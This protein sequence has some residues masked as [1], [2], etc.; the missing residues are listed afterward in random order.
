MS[1]STEILRAYYCPLFLADTVSDHE[2]VQL[3]AF[4]FNRHFRSLSFMFV[5]LTARLKII[6]IMHDRIFFRFFLEI[7]V[8]SINTAI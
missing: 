4:V 3:V 7:C 1:I 8:A 6:A 2:D 5:L